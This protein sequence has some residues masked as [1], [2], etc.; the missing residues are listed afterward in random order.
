M[1]GTLDPPQLPEGAGEDEVRV[2][3]QA[4]ISGFREESRGCPD[5]Y[6]GRGPAGL[7]THGVVGCGV[8]GFP[9]PLHDGRRA[10]DDRLRMDDRRALDT[11]IDAGVARQPQR[12]AGLVRPAGGPARGG[13]DPRL[14]DAMTAVEAARNRGPGVRPAERPGGPPLASGGDPVRTIF[15]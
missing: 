2:A 4:R 7:P 3:E 8:R 13:V 5:A 10:G 11:L 1:V 15:W 6:R 12:G 9:C 14:R